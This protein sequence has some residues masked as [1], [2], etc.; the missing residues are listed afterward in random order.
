MRFKKIAALA[1]VAGGLISC[2]DDSLAPGQGRISVRMT[3]APLPLDEVESISM[4]VVRIEAKTQA[5]TEADAN[6]DVE[7]DDSESNGWVVLAEPNAAFDLMDLRDGVSAF[8]GDAAVAAGSYR[9]MRLILDTQQSS[10]TLKDGT[11]LTGSS[12]PSILFPSAGQS[13]IK[14]IFTNPIEVDEDETTDVL[15]DFDA[16]LSFVVRGN[17]ILQNG[18]LFTPVIRASIQE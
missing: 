2:S 6:A 7:E 18:L 10:V 4:F 12:T 8:M 3:D 1:L 13:G 16:E 11:V 15:I 5:T 17:T 14:I 9:S